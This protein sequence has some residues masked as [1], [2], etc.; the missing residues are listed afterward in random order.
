MA[1][2][3]LIYAEDERREELIRWFEAQTEAPRVELRR[4][5]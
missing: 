2:D 4:H 3:Y 5:N 1:L